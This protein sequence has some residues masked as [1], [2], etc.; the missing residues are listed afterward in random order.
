MIG[1]VTLVDGDD[2]HWA[3][4]VL[5]LTEA[6]LA[7]VRYLAEHQEATVPEMQEQLG[8]GSTTIRWHLRHI[9]DTGL[10]TTRYA[11]QKVG[12]PTQHW[13]VVPEQLERLRQL[14]RR[15]I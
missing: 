12:R 10:L 13:C 6:R 15:L 2:L 3:L 5:A 11:P 9:A 8:L 7:V 1:G 4:S 14:T